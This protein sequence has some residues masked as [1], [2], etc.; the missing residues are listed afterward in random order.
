MQKG[1]ERTL[2]HA[3][4]RT[5]FV[6]GDVDGLVGGVLVAGAVL[7][8]LLGC[9]EARGTRGMR[10]GKRG[11]RWSGGVDHDFLQITS[12]SPPFWTRGAIEGFGGG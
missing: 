2:Y 7:V 5:N 9:E 10:K 3:P 12:L 6:N 1:P 11:V 4:E 8:G